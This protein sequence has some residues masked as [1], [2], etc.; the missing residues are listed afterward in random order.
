M[1]RHSENPSRELIDGGDAIYQ[2]R[3][4]E[5]N[6]T[7]RSGLSGRL[8]YWWSL[9]VAALLLLIFGPPALLISWTAG[10]REWVYP[11]AL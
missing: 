10:H 3:D 1:T 6:I 8:L 4:L 5:S 11:W 2:S 7:G 9:V